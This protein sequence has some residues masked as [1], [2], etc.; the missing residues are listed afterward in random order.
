MS[1]PTM[2]ARLKSAFPSG[3]AA[4][5]GRNPLFSVVLSGLAAP[6]DWV[7]NRQ[8]YTIRQTRIL[9]A[10][11]FWLDLIAYDFFGTRFG[12][13]LGELDDPFRQRIVAEILRPRNTRAAVSQALIDLTGT[14]PVIVELWNTDDCG[15]YEVGTLAY[16][17]DDGTGGAGLYGSYDFPNQ[18]LITAYRGVV[19]VELDGC[20]GFDTPAAAYAGDIYPG[21]AFYAPDDVTSAA[22]DSEI[23]ATI[24]ATVSGGCIGWT[25]I[26][27]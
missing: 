26:E 4:P 5:D 2:L 7:R 27:S 21:A 22:T 15:A 11:A 14:A 24:A 9:T 19:N 3:W 23:Y 17:A 8:A 12:R 6:L 1:L 18:M 25:D 16:A 20:G 13:R 10:G